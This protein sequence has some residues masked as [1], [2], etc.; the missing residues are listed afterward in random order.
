VISGGR[1]KQ[2]SSARSFCRQSVLQFGH[3]WSCAFK[4]L[5]PLYHTAEPR[6]LK[7][8]KT[9]YFEVSISSALTLTRRQQNALIS[10]PHIC[11]AAFDVVVRWAAAISDS[12]CIFRRHML[13]G[14][15]SSASVMTS[16]NRHSMCADLKRI[17]SRTQ[18]R[19]Y[20][21]RF[22]KSLFLFFV[23]FWVPCARWSWPSSQPLSARKYT[24]PHRII[25]YHVFKIVVFLR[26]VVLYVFRP[27]TDVFMGI[28]D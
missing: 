7:V 19:N 9:S 6:L 22:L 25:S 13:T 5:Y 16:I 18:I 20:V 23:F 2:K 24:T 26:R 14:W 15:R 21:T 28:A 1:W 3:Q 27:H 17:R 12:N 8:L 4:Q 10:R 11:I